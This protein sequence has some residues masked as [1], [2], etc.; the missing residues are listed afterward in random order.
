MPR[1]TE[2]T[3]KER[4]GQI[5]DAALR[6]FQRDGFSR[7]SMADIIAESGMSAGSIYSHFSSKADLVRFVAVEVLT[8]RFAAFAPGP[9]EGGEIRPPSVVIR[10]V[11]QDLDRER[12]QLLLQVWADVRRDEDVASLAREQIA[13]LQGLVVTALRPWA[14]SGG[15]GGA[16]EDLA[17]ILLTA[18]QG[19]VVRIAVDPAVDR[20]ELSGR[21]GSAVDG[22]LAAAVDSGPTDRAAR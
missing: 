8:I 6:C 20:A 17:D 11:T 19:F 4:R 15:Y 13:R 1:L 16:L 7:T 21:L 10:G 3:R 9:G 5:A 14:M 2:S 22:W 18:L 12:A